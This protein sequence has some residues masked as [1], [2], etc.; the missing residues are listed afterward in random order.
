MVLLMSDFINKSDTGCPILI[1]SDTGCPIY[2]DGARSSIR[3]GKMGHAMSHFPG[4]SVLIRSKV[5]KNSFLGTGGFRRLSSRSVRT[6]T[7]GALPRRSGTPARGLR[8]LD[9]AFRS[10]RRQRGREESSLP[11]PSQLE[12]LR[13]SQLSR[14]ARP[15]QSRGRSACCPLT[16][17]DGGKPIVA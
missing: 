8:P 16:V 12:G 14:A 4:S 3:F 15:A 10:P 13:R 1:K 6:P 5:P 11:L 7:L 9:R 17:L 2:A